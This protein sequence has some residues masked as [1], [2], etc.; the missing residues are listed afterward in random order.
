M[1]PRA[2]HENDLSG[3]VYEDFLDWIGAVHLGLDAEVPKTCADADVEEEVLLTSMGETLLGP[4]QIQHALTACLEV[5][6]SKG[7]RWF[8]LSFWGCEDAPVSYHG[9]AHGFDLNGSHHVHLL[10]VSSAE[11]SSDA[12]GLLVEATNSLHVSV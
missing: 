5:M 7:S 10:V 4:L 9:G 2:G 3:E 11:N 12:R 6:R 1:C 8:L